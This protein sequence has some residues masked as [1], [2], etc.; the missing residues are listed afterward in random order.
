MAQ[1]RY[2][3]F[4]IEAREILDGLAQG[5]LDLEKRVDAEL[6][7]RLLRLAHT[8]KGAARIV[9]HRE[10]TELAHRM[11]DV[12]APLRDAPAPRRLDEGLAI[13]DQ[14]EVHVTALEAQPASP[15]VPAPPARPV[16]PPPRPAPTQ[17]V[18]RVDIPVIASAGGSNPEPARSVPRPLELPPPRFEPT[19]LDDLLGGIAEIHTLVRRLHGLDDLRMLESRV[20]QIER[21]LREVRKDAEYLR[22][23]TAGAA[24][25]ALERTARDAAHVA[26]KQVAFAGTGGEIRIDAQVLTTLHGALVQ[27]VKNAVAHGIEP[28]AA[29]IAAGKP[30]EGRVALA[31][32]LHGSRIAIT[33]QDDGGGID[34]EAVRGAAMRRG[35]AAERARALDRDQLIGLVLRGGLSTSPEITTISGRGIGLD[36]VHEA[37]QVLGGE[38]T[39]RT[40]SDGTAFRLVVPTSVAAISALTLGA[41]D[42][43][44]ALPLS[45]VRRVTR[46]ATA[47]VL[48]GPDGLSI[49]LD[50]VAIPF[51]PLS[52]LLGAASASAYRTIVIVE[53]SDGLAA[54]GADHVIGVE[55][56]VVRSLP[57]AAPIDPIVW[58]VA[59]DAEGTPRPV[60]DPTPLV[61]AVRVLPSSTAAAPTRPLP[62]LV[63]DDSLTTRMLEQSI[64]ESAGYEVELATSAE[65]GL[66]KLADRSYGLI[67]VDVEMPGMDG[68]GFITVLRSQ[69]AHAVIP[70]ILVTS[71]SRPE[72]FQRGVA[73]GA[74]GYVVK[75]DFDQTRLLD[76]IRRL[77]LR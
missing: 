50:D 38:L 68:F 15:P 40:G 6:I 48:S 22:L 72:D 69:P 1:D 7:A 46:T 10:L 60:L 54:I 56:L 20:D 9:A 73:V 62:V 25:T 58:G 5:L 27:L 21:E 63:V 64:L 74:Q 34:L 71:R 31:V 18:Q 2:K 61:A 30:V 8:L 16:S 75:G 3:Y 53:G 55:D 57:A 43:I 23:L 41:G 39:V 11:E 14:M 52:R 66:A 33:C 65:E 36:V 70:A 49:A 35:L 42:H 24:F 59:L 19:R 77:V 17:L 26:G 12:L 28:P 44:A 37:I 51:A 47:T 32:E 76:M 67:L 13:V 4:R 45:A 29:R